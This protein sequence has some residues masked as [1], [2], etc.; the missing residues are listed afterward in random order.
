MGE[1]E[2]PKSIEKRFLAWCKAE[3]TRPEDVDFKWDF[4]EEEVIDEADGTGKLLPVDEAVFFAS[5]LTQEIPAEGGYPV[6]NDT[7][8]K[9]G[10]VKYGVIACGWT[11]E[12]ED[13][14]PLHLFAFKESAK[15]SRRKRERPDSLTSASG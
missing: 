3:G 1:L 14:Q 12:L 8:F 15:S 5:Y 13:K 4:L 2:V 6:W 9:V 10:N 7:T 11:S